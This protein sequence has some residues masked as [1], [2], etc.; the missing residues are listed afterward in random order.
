MKLAIMQP[1]IF[2]YIGYY[3][4]ILAVDKFVLYDDVNFIKQGWINRNQILVN[5]SSYLFSV[6]VSKVSSFCLIKNTKINQNTYFHW[7][8]KFLKTLIQAYKKAPHFQQIF[9]LVENVFKEETNFVED[10]CRRS[11]MSV[12]DYLEIKTPF[13]SASAT[14]ENSSLSGQSRVIDIC[15]KECAKIYVNPSGGTELYDKNA[16]EENNIELYFLESRFTSYK[17]FNDN[18]INRLSI[19]DVLMFNSKDFVRQMLG[20]FELR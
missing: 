15:H 8:E 20:N 10:L 11:L 6:P 4:L 7:Q 19:I 12:C 2:P 18:F 3:Q 17:Q 16:F 9:P 13:V 14:Y 1:Y 5:G